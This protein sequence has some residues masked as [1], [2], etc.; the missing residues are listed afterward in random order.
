MILASAIVALL[1]AALFRLRGSAAFARWT[2][3]GKTTA[4]AAF[5]IVLAVFAWASSEAVGDA[6]VDWWE[7]A[8]VAAALWFG[9]R[10]GWW[11][12]LDLGRVEGTFWR[13]FLAHS[14]RGA[15]WTAPAA[16]AVLVLGLGPAVL[17]LLAGASAGV[18]YEIGWR[19]PSTVPG[20]RQGTE[21]GEALFGGAI[22]LAL[23]GAVLA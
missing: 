18:A 13:D 19:I 7:T 14:A 10:L 17:L 20:L 16:I 3:R 21:I 6:R 5:A 22:G 8:I 9:G 1:G 11:D 23:G 15:L 2:G 4:D 12:S